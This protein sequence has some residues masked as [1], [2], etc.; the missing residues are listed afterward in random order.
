MNPEIFIL[1]TKVMWSFYQAIVTTKEQQQ[2][3]LDEYRKALQSADWTA[4]Y[5]DDGDEYRKAKKEF[6]ALI[7]ES[8]TSDEKMQSLKEYSEY[9]WMTQAGRK[10]KKP[11]W[12]SGVDM[13]YLCHSV[14]GIA[15]QVCREA[16]AELGQIMTKIY[17]MTKKWQRAV[18]P[19]VIGKANE[20]GALIAHPDELSVLFR[21]AIRLW[22]LLM[23]H[24]PAQVSD[25]YW[26]FWLRNHMFK[27]LTYGLNRLEPKKDIIYINH[28]GF[29]RGYEG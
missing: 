25:E 15:L 13:A 9:Q 14:D 23:T 26:E 2:R 11:E 24:K 8:L 7:V 18:G 29:L 10:V 20:K 27:G 6:D 16:A 28:V 21:M 4:H 5:S 3:S 12:I 19:I 22:D 17:G 1:G